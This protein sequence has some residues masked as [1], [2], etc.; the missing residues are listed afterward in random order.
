M[1]KSHDSP[2]RAIRP[3]SEQLSLIDTPLEWQRYWWGM[4]SYAMGDAR[5]TQ[6]ITV[7]FATWDDVQEFGRR[8]GVPVTRNTDSLWFPPETV[9]RPNEW[10]YDDE[11]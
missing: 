6:R 2:A 4:P 11:S 8:L 1:S 5:P 10:S 9:S 7:N 3:P